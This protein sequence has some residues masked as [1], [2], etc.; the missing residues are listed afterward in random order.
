V[1][2]E[3]VDG[4][5]PLF[6]PENDKLYTTQEIA[7]MFSVTSETVRDWISSG[8]LP[9]IRLRSGHLRVTRR[10]AMEFANH[11]FSASDDAVV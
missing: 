5:A 7:T 3:T 8:R 4:A 2:K 9:A 6:D 11:R 1:S 10:Q